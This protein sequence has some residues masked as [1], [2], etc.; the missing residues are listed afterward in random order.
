[1][2]LLLLS[3]YKFGKDYLSHII[4]KTINITNKIQM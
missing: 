1:M 2:G 3:L 4:F